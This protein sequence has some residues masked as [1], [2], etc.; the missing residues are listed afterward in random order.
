VGREGRGER[1]E[2]NEGGREVEG[3]VVG[4]AMS[5]EIRWRKGLG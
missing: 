5:E 1:V 3:L 2:D 4:S